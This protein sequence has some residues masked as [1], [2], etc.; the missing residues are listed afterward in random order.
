MKKTISAYNLFYKPIFK[1]EII[2]IMHFLSVS[3]KETKEKRIMYNSCL[4]KDF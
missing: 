4:V 3:E 2:I 1:R